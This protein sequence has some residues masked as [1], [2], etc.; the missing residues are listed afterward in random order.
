MSTNVADDSAN[1]S[2]ARSLR[3]AVF[4][5]L[6]DAD[7]DDRGARGSRGVKPE[8]FR[9]GHRP[10][11]AAVDQ[12]QARADVA[13]DAERRKRIEVTLELW[14]ERGQEPRRALGVRGHEL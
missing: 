9:V 3:I 5:V 8:A 10:V 11:A 14:R 6:D 13:G 7:E 1:T 4:H 12:D 2:N